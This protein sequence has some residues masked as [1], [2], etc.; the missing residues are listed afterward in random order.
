MAQGRLACTL[1]HT[2]QNGHRKAGSDIVPLFF[3]AAALAHGFTVLL[4]TGCYRDGVA[5]C[6]RDESHGDQHASASVTCTPLASA[7]ML[8]LSA[9]ASAELLL[10]LPPVNIAAYVGVRTSQFLSN[11]DHVL[12][13]RV[14]MLP[15]VCSLSEKHPF[16]RCEPSTSPASDL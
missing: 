7:L 8:G 3:F 2:F 10:L 1:A 5:A 15:Q 13:I 16:S 12:Q 11:E 14:V 6:P 4:V 9:M